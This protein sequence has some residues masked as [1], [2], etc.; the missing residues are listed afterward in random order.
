MVYSCVCASLM[1]TIAFSPCLWLCLA[2]SKDKACLD[3]INVRV[4]YNSQGL[5]EVVKKQ[6]RSAKCSEHIV[7]F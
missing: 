4:Q 5:V 7:R 6:P 2:E 1:C 3:S